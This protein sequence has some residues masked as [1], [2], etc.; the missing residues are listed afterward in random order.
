MQISGN[1]SFWQYML[2]YSFLRLKV[3]AGTEANRQNLG[4]KLRE[5]PGHPQ[6]ESAV[7][8]SGKISKYAFRLIL[9]K[10][11]NTKDKMRS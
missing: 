2:A 9:M 1:F 10:F 3:L 4:F 5:N 11:Q 8:N 7:K 6:M